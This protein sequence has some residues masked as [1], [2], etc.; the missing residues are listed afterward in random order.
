MPGKYYDN[1]VSA[2]ELQIAEET[3]ILNVISMLNPS[4]G[5]DGNQF[6]FLFGENLQSGIA[7]FGDTAGE[8]AYDFW[9]S[10]YNYKAGKKH[11]V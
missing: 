2:I 10:F 5:V 11:E 3:K 8:A 9:K 6:Y 1:E 7:G 4:F